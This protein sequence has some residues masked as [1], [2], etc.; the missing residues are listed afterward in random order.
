MI[1]LMLVIAVCCI[2]SRFAQNELRHLKDTKLVL[3]PES[4]DYLDD[5][6]AASD[7]VIAKIQVSSA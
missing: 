6:A 5:T 7:R 1:V 2:Y 4:D 3:Y